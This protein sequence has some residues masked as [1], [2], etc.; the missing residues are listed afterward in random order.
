MKHLLH[1]LQLHTER[2]SLGYAA[3]ENSTRRIASIAQIQYLWF[4]GAGLNA[5]VTTISQDIQISAKS[6][7]N[8]I[9]SR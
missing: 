4:L 3:S 1:M 6:R 8:V 2:T 5:R 7:L 9:E